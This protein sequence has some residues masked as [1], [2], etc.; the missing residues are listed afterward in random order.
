[1]SYSIQAAQ[2]LGTDSYTI[3]GL[4][5]LLGSENPPQTVGFPLLPSPAG[6]TTNLTPGQG[7]T[8]QFTAQAQVVRAFGLITCASVCYT[9]AT[10]GVSYVY[11]ANAGAI[12]QASFNTA[13][14]AIGADDAPYGSVFVAYA[15]PGASDAGYQASVQSLVNWGVPTQ[16]VVEISNLFVTQFGQN[17]LLQLGY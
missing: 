1:M 7:A 15:H 17:N 5:Q 3:G 14:D 9:N 13:I 2:A 8:I 11:H 6:Q 10:N 4:V 12:S 16:Q